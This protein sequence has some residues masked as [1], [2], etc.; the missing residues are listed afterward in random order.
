MAR[1]YNPLLEDIRQTAYRIYRDD[2]SLQAASPLG[3]ENTATAVALG[4]V[5]RARIE[6]KNNEPF[7]SFVLNALLEFSVNGGDWGPCTTSSAVQIVG[8]AYFDTGDPTLTDRLETNTGNYVAGQGVDTQA[9]AGEITLPAQ[10]HTECEWCLRCVGLQV[11]D[12]VQL[13]VVALSAPWDGDPNNYSAGLLLYE[14]YPTLNLVGGTL[15]AE[16]VANLSEFGIAVASDETKAYKAV[17]LLD[18]VSCDLS[19]RVNRVITTAGR[20]SL[21]PRRALTAHAW[22]EGAITAELTPNHAP[23]LFLLAGYAQTTTGSAAPYTHTFTLGTGLPTKSGT[24]V[25][26]HNNGT[27]PTHEVYAGLVARR[28]S[29]D[30]NA[31]ASDSLQASLDLI[32]LIYGVSQTT[33][34]TDLFAAAN[35]P[36]DADN[37]FVQ[38]VTAVEMPTGTTVA[39]VT[40]ASINIELQRD[41]RWTLRGRVFARGQQPI[42]A[43]RVSG[44][45]TLVFESDADIKRFLNQTVAAPYMHA[46]LPSAPTTS[47]KLVSTNKQTGASLRSLEIT[48]PVITFTNLSNPK[49]R[50]EIVLI[51]VDFEAL[52][53]SASTSVVQIVLKNAAPGTTYA[54]ATATITGMSL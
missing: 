1:V 22:A 19:P 47:L 6:I 52:Y 36:A 8:S 25:A 34:K 48:L 15:M 18:L 11:G 20:G 29:I 44:S 13:R 53:D 28:I 50:D 32:G 9:S 51:D 17:A 31:E 7:D 23:F 2:G 37:P 35:P 5:F 12:V 21:S 40:R 54:D 39:H 43:V 16:T 45:M 30:Y 24:I 46:D 27:P 26:W 38:P 49:R 10:Y 14:Q 3:A 41:L 4:Q 33:T 42:R